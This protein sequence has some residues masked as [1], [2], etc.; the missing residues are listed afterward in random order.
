M[1]MRMCVS[2]HV[3]VYVCIC[4]RV[5]VCVCVCVCVRVFLYH[6]AKTIMTCE[7]KGGRW[8]RWFRPSNAPNVFILGC[9]SHYTE[10]SLK[11]TR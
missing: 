6:S 1:Y 10:V 4:V 11:E 9:H 2:L 3:C 7:Y 5:R 8:W